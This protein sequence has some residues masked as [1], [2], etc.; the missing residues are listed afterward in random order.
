MIIKRIYRTVL[1]LS[2]VLLSYAL[3]A[4]TETSGTYGSYSP[5][6][7]YGVG[8]MVREGTARTLSMGGV[9][10][11]SRNNSFINTTNPAAVAS[12]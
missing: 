12:P 9:G 5:Y 8:G 4:Q 1:T 2:A 7:I 6:S 11:A 10:I 3:M